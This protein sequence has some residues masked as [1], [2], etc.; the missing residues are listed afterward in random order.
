MARSMNYLALVKQI[1]GDYSAAEA[2]YRSALGACEQ[3]PVDL[4]AILLNQAR[5]CGAE[6]KL[7]QAEALCRRSLGIH[8]SQLGPDHPSVA[9]TL[10][11]LGW[12]Q[13]RRGRYAEAE[14]DYR[15]SLAIR[16]KAKPASELDKAGT[17]NDLGSLEGSLGR[18]SEAEQ[19]Y[20]RVLAIR[21]KALGAG[22][23]DVAD[24]MLR[25]AELYRVQRQFSRAEHLL[26]EAIPTLEAALGPGIAAW[27]TPATIWGWST[28]TKPG[29]TMPSPCSNAR[30][31]STKR[32]WAKTMFRLPAH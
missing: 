18:Y 28:S 12:I 9:D 8:R 13:L 19:S 1:R 21:Q 11:V 4:A 10:D 6:G 29:W 14:S 22:H 7:D 16:E 31:T 27:L 26:V 20:R 23:P 32:F 15:Q 17:L 5:L 2:L 24:T 30:S 3:H 25:L